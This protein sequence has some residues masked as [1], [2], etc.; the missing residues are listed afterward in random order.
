M[1]KLFFL[2]SWKH[3]HLT[4]CNFILANIYDSTANF[5]GCGDSSPVKVAV[6][7]EHE[8]VMEFCRLHLQKILPYK[9]NSQA[10][11]SN[12][13]LPGESKISIHVK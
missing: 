11:L 6:K 12:S 3:V 2:G 4:F 13:F 10:F 9:N 7:S 8:N 5:W 1:I